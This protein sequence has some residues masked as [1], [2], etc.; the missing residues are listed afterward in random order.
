MPPP[1]HCGTDQIRNPTTLCT[2]RLATAC[3]ALAATK[4]G[5]FVFGCVRIG[6]VRRGD[7]ERR[8]T[9]SRAMLSRYSHVRMEAKRRARRDRHAPAR[10]R[11]GAM[12]VTLHRL[13][14]TVLSLLC[15]V[16]AF[17]AGFSQNLRL[18]SNRGDAK[19]LNCSRAR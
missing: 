16:H 18:E 19:S 11:L 4:V 1:K 2:R 15:G 14:T 8:T 7:Q 12:T 10:Q 3:S 13:R 6:R 5:D 9:V 17:K